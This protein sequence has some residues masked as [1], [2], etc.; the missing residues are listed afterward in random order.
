[1]PGELAG[2]TIVITGAASGI[3][4]AYANVSAREGATLLLVD[5]NKESLAEKARELRERDVEVH[6][7]VA[8][9]SDPDQVD[10]AFDAMRAEHTVDGAFLNAGING[11]ASFRLP[12]GELQNADREV[13]RRVLGVNLDGLFYTLQRT[14]G[15]LK[16]TGHG[17]IVV[18]GSTAGTRAE[19]LIGYAY[20]ASKAAVHAV[21][22]QA[23]LEL[24]KWGIRI[25]V[26]APGSMRTNIAGPLPAPPEKVAIWNNSI[27]LGRHGQP[28]ELEEL[29]LLLISETRSSFAT[30][31]IFVMDGGAS[32]LTQVTVDTL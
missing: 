1:M 14:A 12:E 2:R 29:A 10:A 17:T 28:E 5:R 13:W 16:E 31:G 32:V 30:G 19:P 8:D 25:N 3:G 15:L 26:I 27:P 7:Y 18:T 11:T 23:A 24:S 21:V 9:I 6:E 22:R 20:V 4:S